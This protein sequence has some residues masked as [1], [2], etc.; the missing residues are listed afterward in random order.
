MNIRRSL[1]CCGEAPLNCLDYFRFCFGDQRRNLSITLFHSIED[2][3]FPY[4]D[5]GSVNPLYETR[6]TETFEANLFGVYDP[7][8][9]IANCQFPLNGSGSYSAETLG[10]TYVGQSGI[11]ADLG[12]CTRQVR[13]WTANVLSPSGA[14]FSASNGT[15]SAPPALSFVAIFPYS[16]IETLQFL[17]ACGTGG[18]AVPF[19]DVLTV[20]VDFLAERCTQAIANAQPFPFSDDSSSGPDGNFYRVSVRRG[21]VRILF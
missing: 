20:G 9:P 16:G 6:F 13:Q 10:R 12:D 11:C 7:K 1:C 4:C 3:I 5:D 18:N 8:Q 2:T 21:Y 15:I 19:S 14:Y 17:G